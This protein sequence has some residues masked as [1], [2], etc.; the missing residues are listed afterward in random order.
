MEGLLKNVNIARG[1]LAIKSPHERLHPQSHHPKNRRP[2]PEVSPSPSPPR[3]SCQ[4]QHFLTQKDCL[5]AQSHLACSNSSHDAFTPA[6]PRSSREPFSASSSSATSKANAS[7][8]AS[9]KSRPTSA[10]P[11]PPL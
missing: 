2:R 4:G 8:P 5:P 10:S 1:C 3:R 7:P 9:R 6:P 11:I